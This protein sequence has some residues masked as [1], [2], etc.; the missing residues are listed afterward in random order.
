MRERNIKV[1][2]L[3]LAFSFLASTAILG[4]YVIDL[5]LTGSV[6]PEFREIAEFA[7]FVDIW[8]AMIFWMNDGSITIGSNK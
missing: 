2:D 8:V 7:L 4:T 6:T 5:A 3:L 1:I